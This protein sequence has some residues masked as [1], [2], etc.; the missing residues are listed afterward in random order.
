MKAYTDFPKD[1]KHMALAITPSNFQYVYVCCG[2]HT[3]AHT[4]THTHTHTQTHTIFI[5]TSKHDTF[6]TIGNHGNA[7]STKIRIT[8]SKHIMKKHKNSLN[9]EINYNTPST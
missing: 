9:K 2:T 6:F 4:R 5:A 8:C 3:H 1:R 7:I